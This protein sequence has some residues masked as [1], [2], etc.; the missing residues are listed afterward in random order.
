M[1]IKSQHNTGSNCYIESKNCLIFRQL[2]CFTTSKLQKLI[3]DS[4]DFNSDTILVIFIRK[5][6]FHVQICNSEGF[7]VT[8]ND[9]FVDDSLAK[10]LVSTLVVLSDH[11]A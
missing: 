1:S 6:H 10:N 3:T 5:E 11:Q 9:F 4:L 2:V 8:M 7:Y